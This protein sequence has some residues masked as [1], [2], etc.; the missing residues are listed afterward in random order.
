MEG[1]SFKADPQKIGV[2]NGY[3]KPNHLAEDFTKI[4]IDGFWDNQGHKG[5]TEG[6]YRLRYICPELP[7]GKRVFL[8]FG[9][10]DESAWLCVDGKLTA[11]YDT[12]DP[13]KTWDKPFLME[14]TGS[15]KSQTEHLLVIRVRNTTGA[16]G[17]WKPLSLMV[18]K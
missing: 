14:V 13:G 5:L 4:R 17:I 16:G 10:V 6:W 9:A 7:E 11:W 2:E 12:A 8:N 15:L 18:E 1:W 3:F